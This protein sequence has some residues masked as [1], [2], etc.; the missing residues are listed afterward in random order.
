MGKSS[1]KWTIKLLCMAGYFFLMSYF[2]F[3]APFFTPG[4]S[5]SIW[6]VINALRALVFLYSITWMY[7]W[8]VMDELCGWHKQSLL[9]VA[10]GFAYR[11]LIDF[12]M[13]AC[14]ENDANVF[15]KRILETDFINLLY[16]VGILLLLFFVFGR[17]KP[18]LAKTALPRGASILAVVVVAVCVVGIVLLMQ[19]YEMLGLQPLRAED[20]ASMPV[21]EALY[22]A[23]TMRDT[24]IQMSDRVCNLETVIAGSL[25]F[26]LWIN[27][28]PAKHKLP[29]QTPP[30]GLN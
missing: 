23:G 18:M 1:T 20:M 12:V 26:L 5:A 7:K 17:R 22:V 3:A 13:T 24:A 2:M 14:C 28:K 4:Q 30:K 27:T 16:V 10:C 6:V 8:L 19:A 11:I 21:M 9:F 25:F 15:F 29:F